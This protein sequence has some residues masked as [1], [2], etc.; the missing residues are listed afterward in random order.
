MNEGPPE[1]WCWERLRSLRWPARVVC[2]H[3]HQ[4]ARRLFR[5]RHIQYYR[6]G[7]CT[8]I[9]SDVTKTPFERSALPLSIWFRA[10]ACLLMQETSTTR[11]L[12]RALGVERRTARTIKQRLSDIEVDPLLRSIGT[13]V[14][15]WSP[16]RG[17]VNGYGK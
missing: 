4:R 2:L 10:V 13:S 6:C 17:G 14:F 16:D 1:A 12:A 11:G 5:R 3:C 7:H 8:R 15:C 9:F